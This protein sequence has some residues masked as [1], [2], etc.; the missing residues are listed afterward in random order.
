MEGMSTI[1]LVPL[2]VDVLRPEVERELPRRPLVIAAPTGSGKSTRVP[3]WCQAASGG[4]VLV[5]EPRR[6]ACRSL[7]RY[8]AAQLGEPLGET[9]G[10]T[11]RFED[12]SGPRTRV[13]F[14][15]P[16]IALQYAA[17]E[18]LAPYAVFVLDEFHERGI[19]TDLFLAV[20]R[21]RR[22]EAGLVVMSATLAAE[23]LGAFLSGTVLQ[24]S[25]E[26]HPVA[27]QYLGGPIVP[28]PHHL[29]ERVGEA[30]RR[31]LRETAGD[32]LVF[33]PGKG[34]I[35]GCRDR[36]GRLAG[37]EL[38]PLHGQ[39]PNAEVDRVF[40]ARGGG[41][42]RVIL[43]TNVA[44]TSVT[45]PGITAIV[46]SGLAR[47]RV[48]RARRSVLATVAISA[49]AADQRRGRAGRL[50][51]GVCYRLWDER[52]RLEPQTAP[53]IRREPLTQFLLAVAATGCRVD[54]LRFPDD[55]PPFALEE[56]VQQLRRWEALTPDEEL[57]PFGRRLFQLP[58][59]PA[60]A[61]LLAE[62]GAGQGR[63]HE[64]ADAEAA[65]AVARD[66]CDLVAALEARAPLRRRL[67]DLDADRRADVS[68][69]REKELT[70]VRC[71]ATALILTLRA[72]DPAR[73]HLNATALEEARRIADQLRELLDL[74]PLSQDRAPA[75][76]GRPALIGALLR[77]WPDAAYVRRRKGD[78]WG[79][80]EEEVV[81]GR[82]S[83]V[84]PEVEAAI[85]LEKE[86]VAVGGPR[87]RAQAR[88]AMPC[89]FADLRRAGLGTPEAE[90]PV[91]EE[92]RWV[93][94]VAV[95]YAGREIGRE[96]RP[97]DGALLRRALAERIGV[98]K[99]FPGLAAEVTERIA[100]LNLREALAGSG[101]EPLEPRAWL[102]ERLATLGVEAP[103]DWAL[104]DRGDLRFDGIDDAEV[105]E[106]TARYPR[107]FSAG[108]A[109]FTVEYDP[110]ATCVT[111]TWVSGFRRVRIPP[112]ALPRWNGWRVRVVEKGEATT[113]R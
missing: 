62:V 44:E 7:A 66:L 30:V 110:A 2:P 6:V 99:L 63:T 60:Y 58:V 20:V 34:E 73:H 54:E 9:V 46:D 72:G 104:L 105:A 96:R 18:G 23:E 13:R 94:E 77:H 74:P 56:A 102:E 14:V 50:G 113:L 55:P 38:L 49:A 36:L 27:V 5:V 91:L 26:L 78:A 101:R 112:H 67:D 84:E 71:D 88:V 65:P 31:A 41:P 4:P 28:A 32:L 61:R 92:G 52:G 57:T 24:A 43:A 16:G 51:P 68:A 29:E 106:L 10:Y 107:T 93:A 76:P 69:N 15:T 109:V 37:V 21:R 8:V 75:L 40:E 19:E 64:H 70:P 89:R 11:V 45:V 95:I 82:E 108:N 80:G 17:G 48:H 87:V 42:R 86:N 39:L 1:S 12:V 103:D 111:L 3:L 35:A 90:T 59:D 83:L 79:N 81:L 97:L 33:L 98:G 22:P 25:G 100:V 47:Q 53:E 85:M